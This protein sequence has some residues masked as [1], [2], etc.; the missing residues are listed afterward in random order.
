MPRYGDSDSIQ[1]FEVEA[2]Y[3]FHILNSFEDDDEV[4]VWGCRALDSIIPGPDAGLNK[5]EWFSKRLRPLNNNISTTDQEDDISSRSREDGLLFSRCYE[6][7]LNMQTGQVRERNLTGTQFSMDFPIINPDFTGLQ[8]R[9]GY[10]QV[11][12]SIAS[13][14]SGMVK[15][16]GLAKLDFEEVMKV[17]YHMFEENTFCTGAAFVSKEG[18]FQED[19]GW[20][21]T[22]VHNEDTDISQVYII[23][24][25]N[26]SCE[27]VVKIT[28]PCRVP[29]GFHGAFMPITS[30]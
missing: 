23:D 29:Y 7:R 27:P 19:D 10:T 16:G 4:V 30:H 14:T 8:N 20:I 18:G 15:F 13:S 22:F 26:F 5:F 2:N 24:T 12:D 6:W 17:E 9:Y 21:I 1:W 3:T 25:N 28:L 11:L